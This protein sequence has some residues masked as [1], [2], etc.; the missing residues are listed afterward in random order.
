VLAPAVWLFLRSGLD[1]DAASVEVVR[2]AGDYLPMPQQRHTHQ[3][4]GSDRTE[5]SRPP[6]A[7]RLFTVAGPRRGPYRK[8]PY[9]W[10]Q[11]PQHTDP[12][13]PRDLG[14]HDAPDRRHSLTPPPR[15]RTPP[16]ERDAKRDASAAPAHEHWRVDRTDAHRKCNPAYWCRRARPRSAGVT[17]NLQQIAVQQDA[18][19]EAVSS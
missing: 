4:L 13:K 17:S 15:R 12:S 9:G 19:V 8:E 11:Q 18:T 16:G 5:R 2:T 1:V 7:A 6:L 3:Y 10:G 14:R